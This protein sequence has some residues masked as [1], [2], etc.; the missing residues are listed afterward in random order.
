MNARSMFL[1][2]CS[3]YFYDISVHI[4]LQLYIKNRIVVKKVHI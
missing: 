4:F 1:F 3:D 2:F